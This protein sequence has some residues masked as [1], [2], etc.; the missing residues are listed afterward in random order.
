MDAQTHRL[1]NNFILLKNGGKD[2]DTI[3]KEMAGVSIKNL[4][5]WDKSY[6]EEMEKI[7]KHFNSDSDKK[8]K[9]RSQ[10]KEVSAKSFFKVL[11]I[12][13]EVNLYPVEEKISISCPI[14]IG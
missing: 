13:G 2:F 10:D 14:T 7:T 9:L 1:R 5:A 4:K 8:L 6:Y 12:L 11:L 3:V